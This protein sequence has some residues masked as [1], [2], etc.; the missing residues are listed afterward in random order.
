MIGFDFQEEDKMEDQLGEAE[1][2]WQKDWWLEA[3]CNS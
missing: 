3:C 1:P 2:L